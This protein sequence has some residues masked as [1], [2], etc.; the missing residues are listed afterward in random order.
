VVQQIA[1]YLPCKGVIIKLFAACNQFPVSS[2]FCGID[3]IGIILFSPLT[4]GFP[5]LPTKNKGFKI[6]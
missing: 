1:N 6:I 4:A 2:Y 3:D 5:P